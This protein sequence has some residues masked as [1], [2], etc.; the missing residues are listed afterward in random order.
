MTPAEIKKQ[1]QKAWRASEAGKQYMK[2]YNRVYR[3]NNKEY[4]KAYMKEWHTSEVGVQAAKDFR[5]S[6]AGIKYNTEYY[7]NNK[8][9]CIKN[10]VSYRNSIDPKVLW[11]RGVVISS[12]KRAKIKGWAHTINAEYIL[13]I[14]TDKCP[15][16]GTVF[17][18]Y[19]NKTV[20]PES[21]SLDRIDPKLGYVI[22]N[23]AVISHRANT[24]KSNASVEEIRKV[25]DW[26]EL[27]TQE[28]KI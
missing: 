15:V 9:Q 26:L 18:L 28:T 21:P 12:R 4:Y 22:G 10:Q 13:S 19:G 23:I 17:I 5:A 6:A 8:E 27:Q 25:A 16:F 1:Q 24:I 11:A 20:G 14:L 7:G 3:E 2:E